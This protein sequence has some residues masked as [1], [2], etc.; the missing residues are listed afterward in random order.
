MRSLAIACLLVIMNILGV[1]SAVASEK[2]VITVYSYRAA[3]DVRSLF[4]TFERFYPQYKVEIVEHKHDVEKRLLDE[5]S[6]SPADVI[7]SVDTYRIEKLLKHNLLLE[8]KDQEWMKNIPARYRDSKNRWFGLT[9]RARIL[10]LSSKRVAPG[11]IQDYE[12]LAAPKWKGRICSRSFDHLYNVSLLSQMSTHLG[13]KKAQKWQ[14]SVKDNLAQDPAGGDRDQV[15]NV[16][17][18]LCDIAI[19]NTYY[20]GKMMAHP[21]QYDWADGVEMFFP[22]QRNRGSA[23]NISFAAI[24]RFAPNAKGAQK[25]LSFLASD[26]AQEIY[27]EQNFEWPV[28]KTAKAPGLTRSWDKL[29]GGPFIFDQTRLDLHMNH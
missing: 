8:L 23:V 13:A 14:A 12:D 7:F 18:G 5:G 6:E 1:L 28:S 20:A 3:D 26:L 16:S 2:Q 24:A 25:L 4:L 22:N 15:R 11:E 9:K 17:Q 27:A 19:G 10:Y 21:Q 29:Y